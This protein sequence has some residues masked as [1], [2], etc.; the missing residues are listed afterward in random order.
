MELR[1]FRSIRYSRATIAER[2]LPGLIAPPGRVESP[3]P[4]NIARLTSADDPE[5]AAKTLRN[6]ISGGILEKERRPGLWV[7]RQTFFLD[8]RPFVRDA[9]VGLVRLGAAEKGRVLDPNEPPEREQVDAQL[10]HLSALRADFIPSFVLTRAPLSGALATTRRPELSAVDS[11]GVRHDALRIADYAEHV[12][13]QGLVKNVEAILADGEE[14]FAAALEYSKD[15]AAAKFGGAK[16]KLSAIVE[17]DSPGL[18]VRPVHRLLSGF[19]D[20][21]PSDLIYAASDFFETR[22]FATPA[23]A[24]EA[25]DRVSR[26]RAAFVLV[27][28]PAMP[29]LFVLRDRP[30]ALPWPADRSEGWRELDTAALEVAF[31]SRLLAMDRVALARDGH[32]SYTSDAAGATAAVERG[33]AQAAVLMRPITLSEIETVVHSGDRLPPRSVSFYP[34]MFAGLFGVSLEDPVY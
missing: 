12:E 21:N 28:P 20:W 25:L 16:Y 14:D 10:A 26:L 13:L 27:A 32:L 34:E 31:F 6:W 33:E 5:A 15:P 19:G 29:T 30:A 23:D 8:G 22:E 18:L 24:R 3:A 2:G 1:P 11:E 7:Y 9:L 17:M 4:G